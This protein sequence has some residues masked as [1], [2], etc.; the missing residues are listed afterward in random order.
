MR[1]LKLGPI[2]L[3]AVVIS[4]SAFAE[5]GDLK[6]TFK[7]T[8]EVPTQKKQVPAEDLKG[9]E[10]TTYFDP[11]AVGPYLEVPNVMVWL[12]TD[13]VALVPIHPDV[14]KA[15]KETKPLLRAEDCQFV[16]HCLMASTG[17]T[18]LFEG[19]DSV[20]HAWNPHF[21]ANVKFQRLIPSASKDEWLVAKPESRAIPVD[22]PLYPWMSAWIMVAPTP[23]HAV[24]DAGGVITIRN[25]PVGKWQ[26]KFWHE[27][28]GNIAKVVRSG[29]PESWTK[30]VA[31]ISISKGENDLGEIQIVP[32][33]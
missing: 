5:W 15:A 29:K 16:P 6:I 11:V 17:Q 30:G 8:K 23:Y 24:S 31:A 10:A 28:H 20:A 25:L 32:K 14:T 21:Q 12:H 26:F 27:V 22:S 7:L 33:E 3:I 13:D 4:S 19:T 2:V 18:V 1:T 9:C